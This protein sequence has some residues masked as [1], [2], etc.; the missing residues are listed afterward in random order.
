M[1]ETHSLMLRVRQ[2]GWTFAVFV[3]MESTNVS[4]NLGS[5]EA[6]QNDKRR[7]KLKFPV[8]L[9]DCVSYILSFSST[10]WVIAVIGNCRPTY[11]R[12]VVQAVS[13]YCFNL[14][15]SVYVH[16][17]SVEELLYRLRYGLL[18]TI[19]IPCAHSVSMGGNSDFEK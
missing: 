8:K 19:F 9:P 7:V 18:A 2:T 17:A 4:Y 14:Q 13:V 3:R 1:K 12:S 16:N 15:H 10:L 11:L 6:T 5:L